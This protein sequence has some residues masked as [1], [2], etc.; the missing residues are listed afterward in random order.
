[1]LISH[2]HTCILLPIYVTHMLKW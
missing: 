2:S 1:M